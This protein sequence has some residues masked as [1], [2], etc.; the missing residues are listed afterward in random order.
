MEF[1]YIDLYLGFDID[2]MIMSKFLV[3]LSFLV[4]IFNVLIVIVV[5]YEFVK[6]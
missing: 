5:F 4:F 1:D 6:I 3:F 2:E